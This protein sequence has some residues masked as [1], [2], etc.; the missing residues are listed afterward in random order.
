M[1]VNINEL[2]EASKARKLAAQQQ[3]AKAAKE[4]TTPTK[5]YRY[6]ISRLGAKIF[7]IGLRRIEFSDSYDNLPAYKTA[8]PEIIEG[9]L[10]C[11]YVLEVTD[12]VHR[13]GKYRSKSN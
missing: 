4:S 5:P 3:A 7:Y 1:K 11:R 12:E 8:D 9:L 10:K 2:I 13:T 6:F